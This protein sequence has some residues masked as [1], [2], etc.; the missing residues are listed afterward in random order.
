[1]TTLDDPIAREHFRVV[2]IKPD[3]VEQTDLSDPA[4]ARRWRYTFVSEQGPGGE[5]KGEWK[6][7]ELWP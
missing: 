6:V 4:K 5:T 7:V 2:V 1:M 3:E